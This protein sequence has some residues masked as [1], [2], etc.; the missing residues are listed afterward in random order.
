MKLKRIIAA[1]LLASMALATLA[2]CK[3]SKE[4]EE[5]DTET[6][7]DGTV[8]D[9]KGEEWMDIWDEN[10]AFVGIEDDASLDTNGTKADGTW[11]DSFKNTLYWNK[12]G[13]DVTIENKDNQMHITID[14]T[15]ST[16]QVIRSVGN[17]KGFEAE[18]KLKF[19]QFGQA[20]G[21]SLNFG[22]ERLVLF[23][24]ETKVKIKSTNANYDTYLI[25]ADVGN[26][27]HV[28]RFVYR[29][30]LASVY[31][32]GLYLTSFTPESN[33]K[34][35][36]FSFFGRSVDA[37]I[38]CVMQVEYA[39]YKVTANSALQILTPTARQVCGTDKADVEVKLS[40]SSALSG[41]AVEVYLNDVYAGTAKNG[42]MTFKSL[43]A[44]VYRLYAK[45]G[46]EVSEERIFSIAEKA[47]TATAENLKS[48]AQKL[49]SSYI[50]NYTVN[51]KGTVEAGD[52][53]WKYY[54]S[55]SASDSGKYTAVVD[56]GVA[57]IYKNGKLLNS[58]VLDYV[59]CGTSVVTAGSISDVT[60]EAHNATLFKKDFSDGAGYDGDMGYIAYEYA[61]EFEYTKGNAAEL[62]LNDGAYLLAV[63]IDENGVA[64]GLAAPQVSVE[65]VALFI[66]EDGTALY[67]VCVADGLA[68]F[69]VNNEWVKSVRLPASASGRRLYVDGEGI[70]ELQIRETKD[71]FL[72]SMESN[73]GDWSK[74]FSV[75]V[76]N[77]SGTVRGYCLKN[78]ARQTEISAK[79]NLSAS[80]S[81]AFLLVAR[82]DGLGS[83][84]F[85]GYDFDS[86]T[87]KIGSS[88][89]GLTA[90]GSKT[91]DNSLGEVTLTLKADGEN[92]YLYC[93]DELAASAETA[94]TG[95]GNTGYYNAASG[96]TL[97]SV[98]Y[99]GDGS[100]LKGAVTSCTTGNHTVT[101]IE[102]NGV[103]YVCGESAT[104][105]K[106]TDGGKTFTNIG[107]NGLLEK[108]YYNTVVTKSGKI[109]SLM[110]ASGTGGY[111]YQT[112]I[113]SDGGLTYEGPYRVNKDNSYSY[114][115]MNGKLMQTSSGRLIFVS[116]ETKDENTGGMSVYYS[117]SD[118]MIWKK[119]KTVLTAATAGGIN[120]QEGVVVEL[121]D[122]HLRLYA[123]N[124][125]GF[126]YY[127]DSDDNGTTWSTAW[128]VTQFIS[129]HSAFNAVKDNETGA[130]YM[131]W[132]YANTNNY[133]AIQAPRSRVALAVS[134]DNAETWLFVADI[135]DTNVCDNTAWK[136]MNIGVSV[137]SSSIIVT[138]AKMMKL[139][140][141]STE[142]YHNYMVTI[143]KASIST[144]ARFNSVHSMKNPETFNNSTGFLYPLGGTLIISSNGKHVW[145]SGDEYEIS[146]VNGKRTMLT[147]EMIASFMGGTL[148][149]SGGTATITVGNAE[150]I[151]TG[152]SSKASI[153]GEGKTMTFEAVAEDGT[154][155]V[156][157]EDLDNLLGLMAQRTESGAI[158]LRFSNDNANLESFLANAGMI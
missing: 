41:K 8:A 99:R 90:C 106:S 73:D 60:V 116:G 19:E 114:H 131:A 22:G 133:G 71:L 110:R 26:D 83:G 57:W 81:G 107:R 120:V 128:S 101:V 117:D 43:S 138:V 80:R 34:E 91:I 11:F 38:P 103:I 52:G 9:A 32:D 75:G 48:T 16:Q 94:V 97:A 95:W 123:R 5:T 130:I 140:G 158:I 118:G 136:H 42:A 96:V 149:I 109:V 64:R 85:A 74:Y 56:G 36:G 17:A 132:E 146:E 37:A 126:L 40:V 155:K 77:S 143:D 127:V 115:T 28:Y 62:R 154:V 121:D 18:C 59:S 23:I 6:T 49:Q 87:F 39:S 63:D 69:F 147:A 84:I 14:N 24:S 61:V 104:L 100:A 125:T 65:N 141:E 13:N 45:C 119:S 137:T 68:Q 15:S 111:F 148:S 145:A 88:V 129:V 30:G 67:R 139:D 54:Q 7:P 135:D 47:S 44:G 93:N 12:I 134:Y 142:Q 122:G 3:K 21:I 144:M 152:G 58:V 27:W 156:S 70:G 33:N 113:S 4:Q 29:D 25:H 79:L 53:A 102:L 50:I 112:Y 66:A 86:K 105:M 151:F 157:I 92:V 76:E 153:A 78:Y 98:S 20:H 2:G 55:Y 150:Y 108:S 35:M 82:Y 72:L 46:D 51:G 10:N 31:M 1:A 124:D 89:S